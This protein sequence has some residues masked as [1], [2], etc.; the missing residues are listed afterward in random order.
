MDIKDYFSSHSKIAIALSGGIDSSYLLHAAV[1]C[2]ADVSAW[3]ALSPFQPKFELRD[4]RA[5]S[6]DVGVRLTVLD[7][8]PL[9][10]PEIAQNPPDRCYRCKTMIFRSIIDA[11]RK[12]GYDLVADGTNASD[13]ADDR[14]GMR[15]L[16]ELG[17]VSPL[18]ECGLTKDDIRRLARDAGIK[19][20]NKPSYSCLATRIMTGTTITR[21]DL[22]RVEAAESALRSIG[23]DDLRVR[24]F[25]GAARLQLRQSDMPRAI[26]S[27]QKIVDA[28]SGYFDAILLDMKGR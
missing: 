24:I 23:F 20:W 13:D 6:E 1:S 15:A 16:A 3:F 5:L 19:I 18:R 10:D 2:G 8:D 17:V 14:P 28:L 22:A 11:A 12:D 27:R 4:A 25:A 21:D 7:V 9:A 26:E